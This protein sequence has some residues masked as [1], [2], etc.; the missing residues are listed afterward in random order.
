[1]YMLVYVRYIELL[2][3]SNYTNYFLCVNMCG[4][5]RKSCWEFILHFHPGP[6]AWK[7]DIYLGSR[8]TSLAILS[9]LF[10]CIF[11]MSLMAGVEI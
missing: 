6:Q 1:M 3:Y 5:Q 2:F 8:I 10:G 11:E 4:E 9:S 7:Q